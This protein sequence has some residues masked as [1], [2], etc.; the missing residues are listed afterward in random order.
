MNLNRSIPSNDNSCASSIC[1]PQPKKSKSTNAWMTTSNTFN[2]LTETRMMSLT[3]LAVNWNRISRTKVNHRI[4]NPM[5]SKSITSKQPTD[6][7]NNICR[8][9]LTAYV[10]NGWA[11][12]AWAE[13]F[14][15]TTKFLTCEQNGFAWN[16]SQKRVFPDPSKGSAPLG[17]RIIFIYKFLVVRWA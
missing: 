1:W 7:T 6:S 16:G 15:H 13:I 5:Q 4:L 11:H 9:M 17:N 10:A 8:D 12:A 3:N 14:L 2:R